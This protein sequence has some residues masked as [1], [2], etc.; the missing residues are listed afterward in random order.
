MKYTGLF[1][2]S[3][4]VVGGVLA[5]VVLVGLLLLLIWKIITNIKDKREYAA[6]LLQKESAVWND[7]SRRVKEQCSAILTTRMILTI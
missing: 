7:V 3:S 5:G 6:F 4:V 2:F 1:F